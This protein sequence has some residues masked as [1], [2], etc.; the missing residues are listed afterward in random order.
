MNG[1]WRQR[2]A[3]RGRALLAEAPTAPLVRAGGPVPAA[4]P[5]LTCVQTGASR[6]WG[7]CLAGA[8][9]GCT[10]CG[11][12]AVDEQARLTALLDERHELLIDGWR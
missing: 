5:R 3:F 1:R 12:R 8:D 10:Y 6:G 7:A 2:L 4:G 9:G 11:I